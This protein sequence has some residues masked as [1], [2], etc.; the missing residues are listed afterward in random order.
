MWSTLKY[1]NIFNTR[2]VDSYSSF[3]KLILCSYKLQVCWLQMATI[4]VGTK[5]VNIDCDRWL[6]LLHAQIYF[7]IDRGLRQTLNLASAGTKWQWFWSLLAV[8]ID[9]HYRCSFSNWNWY[10]NL[11]MRYWNRY[12]LIQIGPVV[13]SLIIWYFKILFPLKDSAKPS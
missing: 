3:N 4:S 1:I 6:A 7:N 2:A 12:R 9:S 11:I 8:K 13:L 10:Q 5:Y